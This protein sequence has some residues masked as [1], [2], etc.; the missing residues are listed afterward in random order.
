MTQPGF[1]NHFS[2]EAVKGALPLGRNAPQQ[3]PHGLYAEQISGTSFTQPRRS[4]F[5]SWYYRILPSVTHRPFVACDA[6]KF[7]YIDNEFENDESFY[8]DPNQHRWAPVELP[9]DGENLTWL[10]GLVCHVGMGSAIGRSGFAA[11]Q[12][13]C[14]KSM[15]NQAF[16]NSDGDLLIVPQQGN[17]R[18][19]TENGRLEVP[20]KY[21]AI[22]PRGIRFAV[23]VTE[24]SRGYVAEIFDGH[25]QL[26]DLGPIGSNG[27]ANTRDFE[28]P[29]AWYEEY[30]G[31]FMVG[32][33]LTRSTISSEARCLSA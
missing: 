26:P 18:I 2:S 10:E 9:K 19:V 23:E 22:L 15:V 33:C 1:E 6:Q 17:L 14:N 8:V 24:T 32:S 3:C 29:T 31:D 21:V 5:R 25:F 30:S 11:Y 7:K 27:L 28:A 16:S 13:R 4:N 20:P 12:Y